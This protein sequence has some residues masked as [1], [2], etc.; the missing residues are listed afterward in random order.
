[1]RKKTF[2]TDSPL[3]PPPKG[4][5]RKFLTYVITISILG[6]VAYYIYSK[7]QPSETIVVKQEKPDEINN[8]TTE[9]TESKPPLDQ[10]TQVEILNGCGKR[11]I[12][13]FFGK[14]L[15]N[16]GFDV[17]ETANLIENG[18]ENFRVKSSRVVDLR[19]NVDEAERA[20]K[21]LGI[22]ETHIV[23][24]A[25]AKAIYDLRIIIG[26]DFKELESYKSFPQ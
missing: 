17:V 6:I 2:A 9:Q 3:A 15:R 25:N 26:R 23:S 12:A 1:M 8:Q 13:D 5:G 20:A 14:I 16:E 7:T 11:G 22:S 4:T 18:V 10:K 21:I 24:Q 19:G